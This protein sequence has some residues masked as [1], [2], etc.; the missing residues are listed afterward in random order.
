MLRVG[1]KERYVITK[2]FTTFSFYLQHGEV[3]DADAKKFKDQVYF[4]VTLGE[5]LQYGLIA[6]GALFILSGITVGFVGRRKDSSVSTFMT[7]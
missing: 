3:S 1:N 4:A 7:F 2:L 5:Y 6:L